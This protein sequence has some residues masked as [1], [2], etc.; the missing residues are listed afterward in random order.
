MSEIFDIYY[1]SNSID[2]STSII[3]LFET[4]RSNANQ[5]NTIAITSNASTSNAST[6]NAEFELSKT[7]IRKFFVKNEIIEI[8]LKR[9]I[10]NYF[11][12]YF[13]KRIY[14]YNLWFSITK[15]FEIF[16]I[17]IWKLI[18]LNL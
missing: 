8:D 1:A 3:R 16:I 17:N 10:E 18:F 13:D 6:S 7:Q 9:Y 14:D 15:N 12:I 5:S 11:R 2:V 4:E